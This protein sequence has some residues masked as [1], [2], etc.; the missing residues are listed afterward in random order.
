M[1]KMQNL[2]LDIQDE[3]EQGELTFQQI[4]TKFGVNLQDVELL[5]RDLID[6]VEYDPDHTD[7]RENS[8]NDYEYFHDDNFEYSNH[9]DPYDY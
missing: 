3:I 6:Q 8:Y 5:Y 4:A 2:Y 9:Y 7:S 1:G